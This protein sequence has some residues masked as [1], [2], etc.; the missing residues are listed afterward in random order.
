MTGSSGGGASGGYSGSGYSVS[1]TTST[2]LDYGVAVD[3][4]VDFGFG[5]GLAGFSVEISNQTLGFSVAFGGAFFSVEYSIATQVTT[6]IAGIGG[7]LG[8]G[9]HIDA[10]IGVKA[11]TGG[12]LGLTS[13]AAG[14]L[15]AGGAEASIDYGGNA[16]KGVDY[17]TD[18]INGR[19]AGNSAWGRGSANSLGP[20]TYGAEWGNTDPNSISVAV[21]NDISVS[22]NVAYGD[23]TGEGLSG[24]NGSPSND[25]A[26]GDGTGGGWSGGSGSVSND[27]AFG[28][29]LGGGI[30]GASDVSND[31]AFGDIGGWG[32][33]STNSF[34]DSSSD[35][36]NGPD[37]LGGDIKPIIIDLDGD[38]VELTPLDYSTAFF[39]I[40]GDGYRN[41]VAWAGADDG[42]LAIDL[43]NDGKIDQVNEI[44][45]SEWH[46]DAAT[47]LEGLQLVFDT[48]H[49]NIF[50]DQDERWDEFRIWHDVNV[51]G[52]SEE[53]EL[54]SLTEAGI[55]SF[56]LTS[57]NER[58][59]IFDGSTVF[60][61]FSVEWADGRE[62]TKAGD[63][64]LAYQNF[65]YKVVDTDTGFTIEFNTGDSASYFTY[66]GN[67]NQTVA[68]AAVGLIGA[69]GGDGADSLDASGVDESVMLFGGLGSDTLTGSDHDDMI[70]GG[71]GSDLIH[72][73]AGNDSIFIDDA[74][75]LLTNVS[76]G[77][78]YDVLTHTG[79]NGF[80]LDLGT[81]G[82]EAVVAT[83]GANRLTANGEDN[84]V[85]YGM[86]G[87]DVLTTNAG[88]DVLDGGEGDDTLSSGEG[89]DVL[90]GGEGNDTL[91]AG[92]GNDIYYFNRGDGAD[93][94]HDYA[95]GIYQ[96]RYFYEEQVAYQY[97]V[98]V[99]RGSGKNATW[100][101]EMRTGYR[102]ETLE[103]YRDVY[104]EIDGGID[105]LLFGYGILVSDIVLTRDGADMIVELRDEEDADVISGDSI[106]IQDWADQKNRI[107]NFEFS[108]Q[109]KL[110]FSRI[111]HGAYGLGGD[112][113]LTGTVEGDFLSGG[114]GADIIKGEDGRDIIVGGGGADDID[115]GIGK[116]FL[117]GDAG[118]DTVD[119]GG[120]DDYTLGGEGDDTLSGGAGNDVLAGEAGNDTLEGGD[121]NDLLLGG[122]GAD[123]LRGG[124][125]DDTYI[126]FR[127][128]G[129]D[130]ILDQK[131]V[132][133]EYQQ[134]TGQQIYQRSGKTGKWVAE[135]RTAKRMKHVDAGNDTL[136]FGYSLAISDLFFETQGDDLLVGVRDLDDADKALA[137]LDDQ[138]TIKRWAYQENRIETFEF[139]SGVKFDMTDI[140]Y[141]RSGYEGDDTLTGTAG[142][143]VLSGGGGDDILSTLEGDDYLIGGAG[144]DQLDGGAG[145]DDLYGGE[146]DD[147]L[148]GGTG[149]DYLLGGAGNDTLDGGAGNDVLTGG[150]G[151]DLLK[152]GTGDD[153]Y[154]FNRGDGKDTIDESAYEEVQEAY[155]EYHWSDGSVTETLQNGKTIYWKDNSNSLVWVNETRTGH[156]AVTR[157]VEGGDDTI[158][159]GVNIDIS[160]LIMSRVGEDML[161]QLA[162]LDEADTT[163]EDQITI[164]K[165]TT[166]EFRVEHLRFIND[167]AVDIG[168]IDSAVT[169]G[170]DNDDLVAQ[171]DEAS[172]LGGS[173]GDDTLTGSSKADIFF[174]GAGND[175]ANGGLGDDI[176]IFNRGDG[177]DTL[178]DSGSSEVGDDPNNPGGDKL[179][180]GAGIEIEDLILQRNG[181]DMVVY[182]RDREN[183]DQL[184]NQMADSITIQGWETAGNRI[185]VFQFF[186]G[187]DFDLSNIV[188]TH[189]GSDLL[190][191]GTANPSNDTLTGSS[192]ADW[193]DGF[194]GDDTLSGLAGDDYIFGNAGDDI[195]NGGDGVDLVA[196]GDGNDILN[197]GLG[198][199]ILVGGA[200]NDTMNG[201]EGNDTLMG[202][203]GGDILNGGAGDDYVIGDLGN[204]TYYASAGRD[205]YRF[206]FGDGNDSYIGGSDSGVNGTDLFV[207]EDDVATESI[208]FERVDNDLVVRLLGSKDTINFA[209]WYQ[210]DELN[211]HI[212]G[213]YAGNRRLHHNDVNSLVS[214]M[215][216]FDTND[217][218]TAYGITA[219]ELPQSVALAVNANWNAVQ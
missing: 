75:D 114:N 43:G 170:A 30:G 12:Y 87:D 135:T 209:D 76:G 71:E 120:G 167:F 112:D 51:N 77:E 37:G 117:F 203:T 198:K 179:L 137:D 92:A 80:D 183:P 19:T 165:W 22:D 9:P 99:Q 101:N 146:G 95:E 143:D 201:D 70:S 145:L 66:D 67:D 215:A 74:D 38:G 189:L 181:G 41:R 115:G 199:D 59:D 164:K 163:I 2:G 15:V 6:G 139:A 13:K 172:W 90:A 211:H 161:I 103:G 171:N 155:T 166:L 3:P 57:D 136:Q 218:S 36:V 25:T 156:N 83:D 46:E 113:T 134:E 86:G 151:D 118:N 85:L 196:G 191:P 69:F 56:D 16:R 78:G 63:I 186:N 48:N 175:T 206:G 108:D 81:I 178:T 140:T 204:D 169:G 216:G 150:T 62:N 128:D 144:N 45:F 192:F 84:N 89:D 217:G 28:D 100:V 129:R 7:I 52:T 93:H 200:G 53:G 24:G 35:S 205:I 27:T 10:T 29:G 96:E 98:S 210:S 91:N 147:H 157:A 64:A 159:F 68:L 55:K 44:A 18:A 187:M 190:G 104:G 130:E 26:F 197:G 106:T 149:K 182:V 21:S 193:M 188:N 142:G 132:E 102:T 154:I 79:S 153:L 40:N 126:Y 50:D 162:P 202:G 124:G 160:D 184:L 207:F 105:T 194:G 174:G 109:T 72:A 107:E 122:R 4:Q 180:F 121:G 61:Q 17:L 148:I 131:L 23:G 176:Y 73:G 1:G 47:D 42:I 133:E 141:A 195:L 32:T 208:W 20:N 54:Q 31:T 11:S 88:D 14:G 173:S 82:V 58:I 111:M 185:E 213:F 219:S 65:G 116:D 123:L 119:G 33:D 152:G 214:V 34:G 39:D 8:V 212:D 97:E 5:I 138:L 49:D 127:G 177:H 94:I 60:G 110:D 158:Q 125:G 168:A